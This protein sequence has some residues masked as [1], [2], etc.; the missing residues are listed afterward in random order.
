MYRTLVRTGRCPKGPPNATLT[1]LEDLLMSR[2]RLS[3]IIA[4]DA[5]TLA[6]GGT[7]LMIKNDL[8]ATS[9]SD[10]N[11][12]VDSDEDKDVQK[13]D[14]KKKLVVSQ[15]DRSMFGEVAAAGRN[16]IHNEE[17]VEGATSTLQTL[18]VRT[19][20]TSMPWRAGRDKIWWNADLKRLERATRKARA[21]FQRERNQERRA[22]LREKFKRKRGIY[23]DAIKRAKMSYLEHGAGIGS[24]HSV[25][26]KERERKVAA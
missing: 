17:T 24:L 21:T 2:R 10:H 20:K 5:K 11:R 16:K 1:V 7:N 19:C 6:L 15:A 3:T 22:E 8:E 23:K 14:R 13:I 25:S 18:A 26:N 9:T 12:I 4:G